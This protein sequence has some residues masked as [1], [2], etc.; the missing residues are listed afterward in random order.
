VLAKDPAEV[1]AELE[2]ICV[3][4]KPKAKAIGGNG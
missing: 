1:L 4:K 2:K 3:E